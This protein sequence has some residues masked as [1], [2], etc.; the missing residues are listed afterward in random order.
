MP[1]STETT[2]AVASVNAATGSV[3]QGVNSELAGYIVGGPSTKTTKWQKTVFTTDTTSLINGCTTPVSTPASSPCSSTTTLYAI[4]G[5]DSNF[6]NK[7]YKVVVSV[8]TCAA[9]TGMNLAVGVADPSS[10]G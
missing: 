2:S 8:E 3:E 9:V 6:S 10:I 7:A 5:Y 1:I 4:G